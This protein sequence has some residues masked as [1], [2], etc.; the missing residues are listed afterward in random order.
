ML[1]V[2]SYDYALRDMSVWYYNK[3]F[4]YSSCLTLTIR[5]NN[6]YSV[7]FSR[8][9]IFIMLKLKLVTNLYYCLKQIMI[10]D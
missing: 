10:R 4:D 3:V 6:N 7:C 5:N 1:F 2:M 9:A 8:T